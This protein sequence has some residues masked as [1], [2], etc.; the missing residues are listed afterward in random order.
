MLGYLCICLKC[1]DLFMFGFNSRVLLKIA[2]GM[3]QNVTWHFCGCCLGLPTQWISKNIVMQ[4]KLGFPD[5]AHLRR[6]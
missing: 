2:Q 1:T 3:I 6:E 5:K 4:G